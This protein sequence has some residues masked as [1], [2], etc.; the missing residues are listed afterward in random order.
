MY[1]IVPAVV[2]LA[3]LAMA[4]PSV[5]AGQAQRTISVAGDATL[6][7]RND[8]ARIGFRVETTRRTRRAALGASSA[9]LRRVLAALRRVGIRSADTSTGRVRIVRPRGRRGR[10]L[11]RFAARGGV[12]ATLRDASRAGVVL[13]AGVDAGATS[14]TGPDFF[15]GDPAALLRRALVAAFADARAKASQLAAAA[16]LTLGRPLSIRESTFQGDSSGDDEG[17]AG[18]PAT[19]RTRTPPTRPGRSEFEAT[20]FVMFEAR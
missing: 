7:A 17:A 12:R 5:A 13:D 9:R 4:L 3:V 1:R 14:V 16:G 18:S 11:R 6:S 15:V 19:G 10:P 8:S 20:V 2:V